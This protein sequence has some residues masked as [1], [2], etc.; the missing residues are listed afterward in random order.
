MTLDRTLE[1]W[2]DYLLPKLETR[3]YQIRKLRRYYDGDHPFPTA[4]SRTNEKYKQL[5]ELGVTN[6]CGLVVDAPAAML[7]PQD[8]RVAGSTDTGLA[9]WER[10]WK[11]NRMNAA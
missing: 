11:T 10:A 6:M 8:V 2:R 7:T 3:R 4:P 1:D 5:A 9:L